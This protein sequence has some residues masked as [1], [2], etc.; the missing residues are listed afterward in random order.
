MAPSCFLAHCLFVGVVRMFV[1]LHMRRCMC[2]LLRLQPA[3]WHR[4][5]ALP[6]RPH[7]HPPCPPFAR[8]QGLPGVDA[9]DADVQAHCPLSQS[10]SADGTAIHV[11]TPNLNVVR[12]CLLSEV[13]QDREALADAAGGSVPGFP[14][15]TSGAAAGSEG[16]AG[17]GRRRALAAAA[18]EAGG[19]SWEQA[20]AAVDGLQEVSAEAAA[21]FL[22]VAGA[23]QQLRHLRQAE[24]QGAGQDDGA[25][26]DVAVTAMAP[27][28][29]EP[30]LSPACRAFLDVAL[31][32]G[33]GGLGHAK[34]AC[35]QVAPS[36]T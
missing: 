9:C 31:P 12:D 21:A 26:G 6:P 24:G 29:T 33:L 18:Q 19:S 10:V 36:A 1:V 2:R 7:T 25:A 34:G 30:V 27:R 3:E 11:E 22:R 14:G 35:G 28:R 17:A 15:A 16:S 13:E 4:L 5:A 32:G 20:A 23:G 8:L